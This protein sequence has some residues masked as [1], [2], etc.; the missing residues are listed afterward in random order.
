[1]HMLT[2]MAYGNGF[3]L[4]VTFSALELP[5][6][7]LPSGGQRLF[8]M[9][10]TAAASRCASSPPP[11][12]PVP[13]LLQLLLSVLL[14][15]LLL[16]ADASGIATG[17]ARPS[18]V[19]TSKQGAA[20]SGGAA[21]GRLRPRRL[22]LPGAC[23]APLVEAPALLAMRCSTLVGSSC[24]CGDGGDPSRDAQVREAGGPSASGSTL[25]TLCCAG[26]GGGAAG[27]PAWPRSVLRCARRRR[28]I[29]RLRASACSIAA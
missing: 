12:C 11:A 4:A 9:S 5:C 27:S 1:M 3:S 14:L 15:P 25:G 2:F 8:W 7:N 17:A 28:G 16:F 10:A 22:A 19:S 23:C 18:S 29:C 20:S 6:P 26:S 24:G 13:V 21:S